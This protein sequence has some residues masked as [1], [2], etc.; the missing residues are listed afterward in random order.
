MEYWL[1]VDKYFGDAGHTTAHLMYTRFWVKALFD[2]GL[3]PYSEPITWRMSGGMLLG[4]DGKKMSKSKGNT[5][6]PRE[7]VDNYG[8]DAVRTYLAFIG[9]Y[10][11]TYPW[12]HNGLIACY[13]LVKNIYGLRVR[14]NDTEATEETKRAYH[15]MVMK[16]T[17]MMPELKMNTA[18]SEIMIFTNHLKTLDSI[19]RSLW[20]GFIK[21]IA[22]FA[23]FVAE[24]LWQEVKNYSTWQ[25]KNSV[26]LQ[27]WPEYNKE[28]A[29]DNLIDLPIQIN[30]KVRDKITVALDI[31]QEE[32]LE[33]ALKQKKISKIVS[34]KKQKK[35]VYVKN[36]ILNIVL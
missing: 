9:P 31:S 23:P 36:K 2:Q 11:D 8:A 32:A 13:R 30:G 24:Q 22:P 16:I 10:E 27:E 12:N 14:V 35:V 26:H 15:K 4:P 3:V 17:K 6:N 33:Q 5:V 25:A 34:D 20:R 18:V 29:R 19:N 21:V 28:L 1:P 7:V